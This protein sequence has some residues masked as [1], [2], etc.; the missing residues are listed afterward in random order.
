MSDIYPVT[1]ISARYGGTYEGG[2]WLAFNCYDG[3]IPY[4]AT[5]DDVSCAAWWDCSS[6]ARRVG[7]GNTPNEA[8]LDLALRLEQ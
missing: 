3:Q 5:G 8:L 6:D 2:R 4:A 7:R 1:I